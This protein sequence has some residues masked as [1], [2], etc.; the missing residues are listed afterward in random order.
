MHRTHCP[1]TAQCSY[2]SE[3]GSILGI[4]LVC[5]LLHLAYGLDEGSLIIG[6]EKNPFNIRVKHG[7][8]TT[9]MIRLML[10]DLSACSFR[11]NQSATTWKATRAPNIL[12]EP[13]ISGL[14]STRTWMRSPKPTGDTRNYG[15]APYTACLMNGLSPTMESGS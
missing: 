15:T 4:L 5:H 10:L 11:F 13:S 12:T 3:N 8:R 6:C 7:Q 9:T 2:C 1:I 14:Y